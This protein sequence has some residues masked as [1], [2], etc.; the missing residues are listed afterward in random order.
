M[1][2]S[3]RAMRSLLALVLAAATSGALAQ[4]TG[5]LPPFITSSIAVVVKEKCCEWQGQHVPVPDSADREALEKL[6]D[7][8]YRNGIVLQLKLDN[9]RSS[10]LID[11]TNLGHT[12]DGYDGCR[13]HR[14]IGYWPRQR[15]YVVDV[16]LWEGGDTY[17]VSARDG[18][19]LRVG[20]PPILSPSGEYAIGVDNSIAYPNGGFGTD[21][22]SQGPADG[23]PPA[24]PALLPGGKASTMAA[25]G[26]TLARRN[27]Y[28]FRR[29]AHCAY[30]PRRQAGVAH[31]RWEAGMGMLNTRRTIR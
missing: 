19:L 10:K 27:T 28:N 25:A 12:C 4:E 17:L 2:N 18:R 20:S 24:R 7:R 9:D 23:G 21:R 26:S 16:D 6:R 11:E 1:L 3:A 14:L 5:V 31:R 29:F 30:R 13:R 15:Q 22:P 8:A